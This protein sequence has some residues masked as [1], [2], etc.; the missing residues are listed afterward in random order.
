MNNKPA[1]RNYLAG[2]IKSYASFIACVAFIFCAAPTFAANSLAEKHSADLA[3][4]ESYLNNIRNLSANFIQESD[5]NLVEGKFYL[6][7]NPESAG[8]MRIEYSTNPQILIVVNGSVL[9][10]YDIELDEIS[11]LSTNT[12]PASFLTRPNISFSAKDV[13]ITDIKKSAGEIKISVMKKNRKEAGE[14]SIIFTTS[15]LKFTR[16][17]VKNDLNQIISVTLSKIDFNST[18]SDKLFVIKNNN[19]N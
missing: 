4:I 15:P 19:L 7:R 17:E 8:K 6:A 3:E 1:Q 13:E 12:T 10:Y 9:S 5:G 16:M 14:F 18:I 2:V 11:R